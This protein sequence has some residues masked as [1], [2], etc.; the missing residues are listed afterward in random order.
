VQE[1]LAGVKEEP[2]DVDA[3]PSSYEASEAGDNA[4]ALFS[5]YETSEVSKAE[6]DNVLF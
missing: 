5:S 2:K 6:T 4:N 1:A 3:Q